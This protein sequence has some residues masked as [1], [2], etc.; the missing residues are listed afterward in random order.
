MLAFARHF[1]RGELVRSRRPLDPLGVPIVGLPRSLPKQVSGGHPRLV[2]GSPCFLEQ[3]PVQ[4][5]TVGLR[6]LNMNFR[7]GR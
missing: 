2:V 4:L 3:S 7:P 1:L 6:S 5:L